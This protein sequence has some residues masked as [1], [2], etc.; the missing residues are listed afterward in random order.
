MPVLP[1]YQTPAHP[2]AWHRVTAPGGYESW[3]FDAE[4]ATG[5]FQFVATFFEGSHFD[6]EYLRR[7]ARYR[8]APTRHRPP[9]PAEHPWVYFAVYEEGRVLARSL[10]QFRPDEFSASAQR[11]EV[12]LGPNGFATDANGGLRLR[13]EGSPGRPGGGRPRLQDGLR[14]TAELEFRAL[15]AGS[16]QERVFVARALSGADHRWVIANPL[17]E[18]KGTVQLEAE[19]GSRNGSPGRTIEFAGRGYHDH[20]FGTAPVGPGLLQWVSGR[21]LA[22]R[23]VMTFQI[24]RPRDPAMSDEVRLVE[25]DA[26]GV[27]DVPTACQVDWDRRHSLFGRTYPARILF[28]DRLWLANP[29]VIETGPCYGRVTYDARLDGRTATAFCNVVQPR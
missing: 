18:V 8:R 26:A 29:R 15:L 20:H 7:Y 25:A 5:R 4:D 21:V 6:P 16:P 1:L 24:A 28:G 10:T 9:L 23:S 14:L 11:P 22:E 3:H 17:C 27:R 2:D 12:R 13:L 19:G